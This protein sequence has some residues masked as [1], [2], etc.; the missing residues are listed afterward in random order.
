MKIKKGFTLVELLVV[1]AIIALLMGIL[2]PALGKAR[3]YAR[4]IVCGSNLRQVGIGILTYSSDTDRLPYYGENYPPPSDGM[5]SGTIHPYVVYRADRTYDGTQ[6]VPLRLACLYARGYIADPKLFYCPSERNAGRIY[7][8]YTSPGKWGTLPQ[9][10]NNGGNQWVRVG[11]AYYPIDDLIAKEPDD[12]GM[13]TLLVPRSTQRI[14]SKLDKNSPYATD[15]LWWSR[16]DIT[17]K[18]GIDKK[19]NII[20]NGGINALFK[21]GHVRYVQDEAVT[22]TLGTRGAGAAVQTG[23]VFNNYYWNIWDKPNQEKPTDMDDSRIVFYNIFRL[24]KP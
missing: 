21:D 14:M 5:D 12:S 19:T 16:A 10:Y 15:F 22:F 4:R 17:H 7:K 3:E 24:I 23:T 2:M 11:I 8:S 9:T 13:T 18:S 6:L 1:I 20:K